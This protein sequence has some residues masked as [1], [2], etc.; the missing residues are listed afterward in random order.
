MD[1][2]EV[3]EENMESESDS[4]TDSDSSAS[5]S[6]SPKKRPKMIVS[7]PLTNLTNQE[8]LSVAADQESNNLSGHEQVGLQ[9]TNDNYEL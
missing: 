6:E 3:T 4:E 5:E 7:I 9:E 1:D 8:Q 2:P